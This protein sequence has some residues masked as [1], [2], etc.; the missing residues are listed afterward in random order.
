MKI[1]LPDMGITRPKYATGDYLTTKKGCFYGERVGRVAKV[2][3]DII[4]ARA[5]I[6]YILRGTGHAI[7]EKDAIK[8]D[9]ADGN[10]KHEWPPYA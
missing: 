7:E 5:E 1:K 10:E 9:L 6:N 8:L 4:G 2:Q 3:I